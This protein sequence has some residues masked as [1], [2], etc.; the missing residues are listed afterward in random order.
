[1]ITTHTKLSNDQIMEIVFTRFFYYEGADLLNVLNLLDCF[2]WNLS[3]GSLFFTKLGNSWWGQTHVNS[4]SKRLPVG[5][6]FFFLFIQKSLSLPLSSHKGIILNFRLPYCNC[7]DLSVLS[8]PKCSTVHICS[9][10]DTI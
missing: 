2:R 1:M 5:D 3:I 10:L 4:C 6:K 8:F 9:Q 7:D